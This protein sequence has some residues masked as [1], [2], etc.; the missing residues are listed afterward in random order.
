MNGLSKFA[1]AGVLA[2]SVSA[3]ALTA[4]A[5]TTRTTDTMGSTAT[6][7]QTGATEMGFGDQYYADLIEGL[8]DVSDDGEDEISA[9]EDAEFATIVRVSEIRSAAPDH[10]DELDEALEAH[11]DKRDDYRSA[12]EDNEALKDMV[13]FS[14]LSVDDVVAVKYAD[15]Q[16]T[17]VVDES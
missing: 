3:V 15:D 5:D 7:S 16:L 4:S 13:E 11:E 2:A 12:I 10:A 14:D 6:E 8:K 1:L 9:I 17:L